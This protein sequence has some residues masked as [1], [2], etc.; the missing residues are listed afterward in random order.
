MVITDH[1]LLLLCDILEVV[2]IDTYMCTL[3]LSPPPPP[4]PPSLPYCTQFI[5]SQAGQGSTD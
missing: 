2:I 1:D 5:S 4:L 3:S